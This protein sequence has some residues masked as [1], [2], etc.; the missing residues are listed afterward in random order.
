MT[1]EEGHES[2]SNEKLEI[3]MCLVVVNKV[4][5]LVVVS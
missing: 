2:L 5:M 4:C 3:S 1:R